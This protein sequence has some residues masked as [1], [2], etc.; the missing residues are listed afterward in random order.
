MKSLIFVVPLA[1]LLMGCAE[2][3][4]KTSAGTLPA[5]AATAA[6]MAVTTEQL[7]APLAEGGPEERLRENRVEIDD[8]I[9]DSTFRDDQAKGSLSDGD[10]ALRVAEMYRRGVNGVRSDERRMLQWLLQASNLNNAAASY[11]LYQ[12]FL[13]QR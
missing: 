9:G 1:G 13:Q 8:S 7:N 5:E 11:Q 2:P 10:A 6:T 3:S 12:Y 4:S